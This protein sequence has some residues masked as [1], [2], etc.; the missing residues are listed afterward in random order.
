MS[1]HLILITTQNYN[2]DHESHY[3][4]L[5]TN[6]F[7]L[8]QQKRG[9]Q[10]LATSKWSG[11]GNRTPWAAIAFTV[12]DWYV[13]K[14][15]IQSHFYQPCALTPVDNHSPFFIPVSPFI[16]FMLFIKL[17]VPKYPMKHVHNVG[18]LSLQAKR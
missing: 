7:Q 13:V 17:N 8:V 2:L 11:M 1:P 6:N 5:E 16:L 12:C 14:T 4:R 9:Y 15:E 18:K 3:L 10:W